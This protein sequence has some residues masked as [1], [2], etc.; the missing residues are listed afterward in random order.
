MNEHALLQQIAEQ[1]INSI[2]DG[3]ESLVI[4][5][6]ELRLEK[7]GDSTTRIDLFGNSE[8]NGLTIIEL[9]KSKQNTMNK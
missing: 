9:K 7:K 5:A 2:L 8:S 3:L 1:R 6:R 4:T